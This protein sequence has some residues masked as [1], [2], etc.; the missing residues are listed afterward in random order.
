MR[1]DDEELQHLLRWVQDGVVSRRQILE[2]GGTATDIRRMLHRR[3]LMSIQRGVM[4]N[5]TG[6]PTRSQQQHAAV[7]AAWP[8]ALGFESALGRPTPD[9]RVRVVVPTGRNVA[10]IPGVRIQSI[11]AFDERVD[12]IQS[13]PCVRFAHA[14]IDVASERDEAD[15]FTVLSDALWTR[16]TNVDELLGVVAARGRVRN[17]VLIEQMLRDLRDG[18]C[19]VLERG[20]LQHVE[21]PHGLP[22]MDRQAKDILGGRTVYRDGEYAAYKLAIELDGVAYHRGARARAADSIRDLETLAARDEATIRLTHHQ[23]FRES[24]RSA[25]LI[26]QI[27]RRRGW[28][29]HAIR[30]STCR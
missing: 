27:L 8:A 22:R 14:A 1:I 10:P 26:G 19:S 3:D 5:H 9:G 17:R 15:A 25:H 16:R 7:L 24:C 12:Q 21:R 6:A 29:G 20:Y 28:P 2:L 23:V 18:T 13:P 11:V 4:V 30:C